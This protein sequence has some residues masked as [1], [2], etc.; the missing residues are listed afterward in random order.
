MLQCEV[1]ATV[2]AYAVGTA[3]QSVEAEGSVPQVSALK[4]SGRYR[5]S[6]RWL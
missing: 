2:K 6:D 1:A 5:W 4:L 3:S